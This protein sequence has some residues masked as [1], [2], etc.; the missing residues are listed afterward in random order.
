MPSFAIGRVE[1]LT[2]GAAARG[3]AA[4]PDAAGLRRQ[5]DGRRRAGPVLPSVCTSSIRSSHRRLGDDNAPH[6]AAAH[7]AVTER[8]QQDSAGA[9]RLRV[10]HGS[11]P[12]RRNRRGV[13]AADRL[14]GAVDRDFVERHGRGRPRPPSPEGRAAQLPQYRAVRRLSGRRHARSTAGRRREDRQDSRRLGAGGRADRA[15]RLDVGARRLD[16]DHAMAARVS[17]APK[18]TFI[19]HGEVTAMQAL[20]GVSTGS[21]AGNIVCPSTARPSNYNRD[22][23]SIL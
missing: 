4:H 1:E 19:V 16:G 10:L 8:R 12:R 22:V 13:Q 6:D 9:R 11:F 15:S 2:L 5:S 14:A 17:A 21:S 18:E 3:R 20:S 23:R 7:E